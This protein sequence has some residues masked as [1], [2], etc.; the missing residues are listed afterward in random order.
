M[1]KKYISYFGGDDENITLSGQSAGAMSVDIFISSP[2]CKGLAQKAILLSAAGLQRKIA[3][4]VK[5]SSVK[6]FWEK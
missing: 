1:G 2:L 5:P 6:G 4:P 3:R